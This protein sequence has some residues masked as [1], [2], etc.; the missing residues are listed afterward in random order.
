MTERDLAQSAARRLAV[1]ATSSVG[2]T[3]AGS[4]DGIRT[5]DLFLEREGTK[6]S[7]LATKTLG[8]TRRTDP[9]RASEK[10]PNRLRGSSMPPRSPGV[11][12][13]RTPTR[14]Q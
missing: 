12:H 2:L 9:E 3:S 7:D 14:K 13:G 6:K 1:A 11:G 4:P 5:H 10:G 8:M